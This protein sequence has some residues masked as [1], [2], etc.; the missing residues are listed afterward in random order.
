L[1]SS[2]CE[3]CIR[4]GR[5]D[6]LR[7]HL[8]RQRTNKNLHIKG[9]HTY[10]SMIRAY[11]SL[12][13]MDEVWDSWREMRKR[14]VIPTSV[15]I[16]CMVEALATNGHVDAGYELIR[17]QLQDPAIRPMV[18][19]VIYCSVLKGFSHGKRFDRVW[20]VY[21]EM[22]AERL[23]FSIVT[24]N[25]LVD[26]CA[27]SGDMGRIPALLEEMAAQGI[28][29]NVITY[30]AIV[31]GYCQENRLDRAFELLE[32]M[33]KTKN[34]SPDE[35]TYNTLIDGC[36]RYGLWDRGMAVLE[37]M[38][39]SGV[40]PSAFTLSVLVKLANRSKRPDKAFELVESLCAKYRIRLCVQ[41]LNN[42]IHA[43]TAHGDL[44][45]GLGVLQ[46]M[47]RERIRPDSR[48]YMLLLRGCIGAKATRDAAGL[49]RA[50][51]GVAG[52]H[53]RLASFSASAAMPKGGLPAPVVSEAL[54]GIADV[55]GDEALALQLLCDLRKASGIALDPKLPMRLTSKAMR[56][57]YG[58]R[59]AAH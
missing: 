51:G 46:Q 9:A 43:C 29:P 32:D 30:S 58:T 47:L 20:S 28:E 55:C 26:A 18:N 54:E 2:V 34:F 4:S 8:Q 37:E 45:R 27:R 12:N 33:K 11:G 35:V 41:V 31:K 24:Y 38:E 14:H 6:L 15:T 21:E 42:L 3:A 7:K 53:P 52:G 49:L 5:A 17:E 36:A 13:E 16:G 25:T 50:A 23:Q 22:K 39:S 56:K 1:M 10:G 40:S 19:A 44:P 48:T 57:P 59:A